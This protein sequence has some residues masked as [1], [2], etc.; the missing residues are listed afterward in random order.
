MR[1]C[2]KAMMILAALLVFAAPQ[3]GANSGS[4]HWFKHAFHHQQKTPK[5]PERDSDKALARQEK[6]K[7]RSARM[8]ER[9]AEQHP[10]PK[11]TKTSTQSK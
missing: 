3:A 5:H 2:C 11:A 1:K 6:A 10:T 4:H 9:A 7:E 8:R